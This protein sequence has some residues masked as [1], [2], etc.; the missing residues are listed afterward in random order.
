MLVSSERTSHTWNFQDVWKWKSTRPTTSIMD[1]SLGTLLRFWGVF[2]FTQGQ[3]L[4]SPHKQ[5]WTRVSI[6]FFRVSTLYRVGGGRTARKFWKRCT[7]LRGNREITEKYEYCGTV[8]RTV[9]D[10]SKK[11]GYA[12]NSNLTQWVLSQRSEVSCCSIVQ[13]VE[14]LRSVSFSPVSQVVIVECHDTFS[15]YSRFV[16]KLGVVSVTQ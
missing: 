2:Q 1:K 8:P 12:P 9:Q 10:C 6:I 7:V 3:P 16:P 14:L 5:C 15:F 13:S 4:P 11:A